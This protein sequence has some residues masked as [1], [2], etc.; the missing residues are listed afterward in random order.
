MA[1]RKEQKEQAR[2][3][4]IAQEQ[5]AAANAQRTRRMQILG[6]AI[7]IAVIVIVV[8]IVVSSSGG[9]SAIKPE[10]PEAKAAVAHVDSVLAGIPE[11]GTT[12]GNPKAKIT[13]TE[14]GDLEC[15]VC[16][17]F[18]TPTSFTNPED[19]SGSG[20][21]DQLINTYVRTGQ[22]KLV[23]KSLETASG[24]NPDT[25]AFEQQ[26]IAAEAAGLQGKEWYYIELMYNQ[27]GA[28]DSNYVSE[29]YLEGLAKE[30]RG[31]NFKKWMSDRK[32][33]SLKNQLSVE[34]Q[35][36]IDVDG[37]P[38][39][40]STPTVVVSGPKG[41]VAPII[42]LPQGGYNTYVDAIKAVG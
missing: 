21:E 25:N 41:S 17:V 23:Y 3:A 13:I 27:Q 39:K 16:D 15:S 37:G 7:A 5:A 14:Y 36:G 20:W 31:L 24:G 34:S 30:I 9:G 4:R 10:S 38:R 8:A 6:G 42:G 2:A 18:A 12:L 35:E 33:A 28:E 11:S 1:S 40:V 22:A 29:S 19:E 26:Q 32:L